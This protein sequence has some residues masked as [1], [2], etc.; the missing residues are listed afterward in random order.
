[1]ANPGAQR[2]IGDADSLSME[3]STMTRRLTKQHCSRTMLEGR[4]VDAPG[5]M[6]SRNGSIMRPSTQASSVALMVMFVDDLVTAA[7][8]TGQDQDIAA[9]APVP[10]KTGISLIHHADEHTRLYGYVLVLEALKSTP[11]VTRSL[12]RQLG[13]LEGLTRSG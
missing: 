7:Y 12:V 3:L 5:S 8:R 9:A 10:W 13:R 4:M 11:D 2:D 6:P 1:M